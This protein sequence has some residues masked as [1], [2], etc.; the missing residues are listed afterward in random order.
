MALRS[1]SRAVFWRSS[2]FGLEGL[3]G[4]MRAAAGTAAC[5]RVRSVR[6]EVITV[7]NR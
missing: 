6:R 2:C 5:V 4:D 7:H 1:D 3:Q